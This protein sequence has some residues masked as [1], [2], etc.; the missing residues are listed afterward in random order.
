MI[1]MMVTVS[2]GRWVR[3]SLTNYVRCDGKIGTSGLE[4]ANDACVWSLACGWAR[5]EGCREALYQC[6]LT[7]QMACLSRC[8]LVG[9][10]CMSVRL[11][12]ASNMRR[13]TIT[14]PQYLDLF[15]FMRTRKRLA[16]T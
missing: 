2:I 7:G 8:P 16:Q 1:M 4:K 9:Q 3:L 12:G 11:D 14:P 15:L 10:M 13:S 6:G 5:V